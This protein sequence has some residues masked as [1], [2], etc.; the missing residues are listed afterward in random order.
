MGI[1]AEGS[2]GRQVKRMVLVGVAVLIGAL[3]FGLGSTAGAANYPPKANMKVAI[4]GESASTQTG[5][6][7][8]AVQGNSASTQTGPSTAAQGAPLPF[9]GSNSPELVWAG[10]ALLVA[11]AA[12]VGHRR[13]LDR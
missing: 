13:R 8:A 12:L 4:E 10:A 1:P 2:E 7:S 9:T 11:G 3:V 6:S 5:P